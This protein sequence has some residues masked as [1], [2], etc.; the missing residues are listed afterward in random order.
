MINY[1]NLNF[2]ENGDPIWLSINLQRVDQW[3]M[4]FQLQNLKHVTVEP[5][6]C[7]WLC[8]GS[9]FLSVDN[10]ETQKILGG[11]LEKAPFV[12]IN[13]LVHAEENQHIWITKGLPDWMP[14]RKYLLVT[15]SQTKFNNPDWL[16]VHYYDFLFNRTKAFYTGFPFENSPWYY[17]G[18]EN[19]QAPLVRNDGEN[20]QKIF[21]SPCRLYEDQNRTVFRRQLFNLMVKYKEDGFRSG[22]GRVKNGAIDK[23]PTGAYL[24]SMT[25]DPLVNYRKLGWHYNPQKK[26]L[27]IDLGPLSKWAGS[28]WGGYNPIH[29]HYF[30]NSFIS[31]YAETI[32]T[33]EMVVITEKTYDPLIKGHFILPFGCA[34]L[35]SSIKEVGFRLPEFIRYD[36]DSISDDA[37]RFEHYAKE[38]RR[39][40]RFPK[41]RWCALL[42]ENL[43]LLRYNQRLFHCRDYYK[44]QLPFGQSESTT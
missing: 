2:P 21:L 36:Y 14:R 28:R 22:P 30:K 44:L 35:V 1:S 9:R 7:D 16:E 34:G 27:N 25:D 3:S 23:T 33:G 10:V 39:I 37:V 17:A 13:D 31:I 43:A 15:N 20:K 40:M 38:V 41:Q 4:I 24:E 42:D 12:V 6:E 29:L 5:N 18:W 8:L 19:Y 11:L 26:S 32:E